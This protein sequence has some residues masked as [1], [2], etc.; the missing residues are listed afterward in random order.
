MTDDITEK[1]GARDAQDALRELNALLALDDQIIAVEDNF[2]RRTSR[3]VGAWRWYL[4]LVPA[5]GEQWRSP[6]YSS[7]Y[8]RDTTWL[9]RWA[10]YWGRSESLPR[11]TA[12]DARTALRLMHEVVEANEASNINTT[13]EIANER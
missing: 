5:H 6:I 3:K 8:M 1:F 2:N 4:T 13:E 12:A 9:R 11:L 10:R 7:A